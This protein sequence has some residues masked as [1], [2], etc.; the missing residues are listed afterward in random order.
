MSRSIALLL[1]VVVML[2]DIA[3]LARAQV[4]GAGGG[5]PPCD[6]GCL[7]TEWL[8]TLVGTTAS[9]H[10]Y[11]IAPVGFKGWSPNVQP[12]NAHYCYPG[13][14]IDYRPTCVQCA[15]GCPLGPNGEVR[16]PQEVGAGNCNS[17]IDSRDYCD[18][19]GPA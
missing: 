16:T 5:L 14:P 4:G 8:G 18:C 11:H 12:L 1:T 3:L 17:E 2:T 10:N 19:S 15:P 7:E 9:C 6:Y 13:T